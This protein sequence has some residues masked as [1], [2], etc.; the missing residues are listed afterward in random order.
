MPSLRSAMLLS[1][2]EP[3]IP[4]I[5]RMGGGG[6]YLRYGGGVEQETGP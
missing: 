3:F 4:A 1:M 6:G 5:L 2:E